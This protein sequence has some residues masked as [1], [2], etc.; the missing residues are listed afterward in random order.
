MSDRAVTPAFL[1]FYQTH[2]AA[3]DAW[4][5]GPKETPES[6]P[7]TNQQASRPSPVQPTLYKSQPGLFD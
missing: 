7:T 5:Q 3:F 2:R 1:P 4:Q 6:Q